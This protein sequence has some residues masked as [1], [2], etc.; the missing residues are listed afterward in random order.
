VILGILGQSGAGKDTIADYLVK[1]YRFVKVALA[2]PLKRVC[3]EVYGFSDSQLWGPS[4]MRNSPDFRY[5]TGKGYLSPRVALQ[6]LGT[7][8]GRAMYLNTWIDYGLEVADDILL[9]GMYYNQKDGVSKRSWWRRLMSRRR[10]GVVFSDIRFKNEIDQIRRRS[11][12]FVVRVRRPGAVGL[13]G[14]KGHASEE[15]QKSLTD[16]DFDY[17]INNTGSLSQLY[18]EVDKMLKKLPTHSRPEALKEA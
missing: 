2:D 16:D 18:E 3:K 14:L 4:E 13:V 12:G 9:R 1:K 5:P 7:E 8:W 15:E 10:Q 6:T 17:T 11:N